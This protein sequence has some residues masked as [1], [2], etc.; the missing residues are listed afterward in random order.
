MAALKTMTSRNWLQF[1]R[2]VIAIVAGGAIGLAASGIIVI[3]AAP[4]PMLP[5]VVIALVERLCLYTLC[6]VCVTFI[7][8]RLVPHRFIF[9][10]VML[11]GGC[12]LATIIWRNGALRNYPLLPLA[13]LGIGVFVCA[14]DAQQRK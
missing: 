13:V 4:E 6:G 3:D 7:A 1:L 10:V 8:Y 9:T 5:Q 2:S 11:S 12:A 14:F